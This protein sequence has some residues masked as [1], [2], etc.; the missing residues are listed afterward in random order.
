MS[1]ILE[2]NI[3]EI[4]AWGRQQADDEVSC[5]EVLVGRS[6]L[7]ARIFA[8]VAL[9]VVHRA[10]DQ[11]IP[12]LSD[13]HSTG[14]DRFYLIKHL[15]DAVS[16]TPVSPWAF[17]ADDARA[18]VALEIAQRCRSTPWLFR[19]SSSRP[20]PPLEVLSERERQEDPGELP[21][22]S[23]HV[24]AFLEGL[25]LEDLASE[26]LHDEYL[27]KLRRLQSGFGLTTEELKMLLGVSRT[28]IQKWLAGGGIS[29]DVQARID[30]NLTL[31]AHLESYL[32]PGLLPSVVRQS[33][34]GLKGKTPLDLILKGRGEAVVDYFERLTNYG[35]TA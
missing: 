23:R 8:T 25:V 21:S 15:H 7:K 5:R 14:A 28:S 11:L 13:S 32:R 6:P 31:L 33:G 2:G 1:I 10:V 4:K 12:R 26:P 24:L 20:L 34:R 16:T 9:R 17:L 22:S 19:L 3:E 18:A 30:A 29:R 27:S 35:A